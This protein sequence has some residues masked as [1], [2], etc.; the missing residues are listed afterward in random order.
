MSDSTPGGGGAF[1]ETAGVSP[2]WDESNVGGQLQLGGEAPVAARG[3]RQHPQTEVGHQSEY[4]DGDD[5]VSSICHSRCEVRGGWV[6]KVDEANVPVRVARGQQVRHVRVR[7]ELHAADRAGVVRLDGREERRHLAAPLRV[8]HESGRIPE[9]HDA[10][11]HAARE[12]AV[13]KGATLEVA[14]APRERRKARGGFEAARRNE[15]RVAVYKYVEATLIALEFFSVKTAAN[16]KPR[17]HGGFERAIAELELVESQLAAIIV[18]AAAATFLQGRRERGGRKWT[19]FGGAMDAGIIV[20]LAAAKRKLLAK[21]EMQQL[22]HQSCSSSGLRM[23]LTLVATAMM[24]TPRMGDQAITA[25]L[26]LINFRRDME[27]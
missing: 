16:D 14:R 10:V 24:G 15:R 2:N 5:D 9:V 7:V 25:P 18:K 4:D 8:A 21:R 1:V 12:N 20:V 11:G 27:M 26:S 13:R 17:N 23:W 6:L 22:L 3:F 19:Q